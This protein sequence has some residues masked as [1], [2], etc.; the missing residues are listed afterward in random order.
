MTVSDRAAAGAG[1]EKIFAFS[2]RAKFLVAIAVFFLLYCV[3]AFVWREGW[4]DADERRVFTSDKQTETVSARVW[5]EPQSLEKEGV[6]RIWLSLE[7]LTGEQASSLRFTAVQ[8]FHSEK[9][10][11]A[12]IT[13]RQ[14][15][16]QVDQALLKAF[17]QTNQAGRSGADASDRPF[18]GPRD[19]LTFWSTLQAPDFEGEYEVLMVYEWTQ[20]RQGTPPASRVVQNSVLV[21]PL[22]VP[23]FKE[24]FLRIGNS[25]YAIW[26]DLALPMA[27]V[28]LTFM[29]SQAGERFAARRRREEEKRDLDRKT[30]E[31][32][33]EGARKREELKREEA[34]KEAERERD[35]VRETLARMLIVSHRDAKRYYLPWLSAASY[36]VRAVE[37]RRDPEEAFY[38][39][40]LL[41]RIGEQLREENGGFYL[42]SRQGEDIVFFTWGILKA[43]IE[44]RWGLSDYTAAVESMSSRE[45]YWRFQE[46]LAQREAMR[47]CREDFQ[48]WLQEDV[49]FSAYM[50][51]LRIFYE[52]LGYEANRP[53]VYW[54]E[55]AQDPPRAVLEEAVAELSK[56]PLREK[57]EKTELFKILPHYLSEA[58]QERDRLNSRL[59]G[60]INQVGEPNGSGK[61]SDGKLL[62][63]RSPSSQNPS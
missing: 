10:E 16:K 20:Q 3:V 18:L 29:F 42:K 60:G 11:P 54:Y 27:L 9:N 47:R 39:L 62:G 17:R 63:H 13:Q 56:G 40:M 49:P 36:L 19:R 2:R 51:L 61:L 55:S 58:E 5:V 8:V 37:Q 43:A 46:N 45:K 31:E 4:K 12:E 21:G 41:L 33:R 25:L 26:K 30:E 14:F 1:D 7:N 28:A 48:K 24:Q 52:T 35:R 57:V 44:K 59:Q 32:K 22:E 6:F 15:E 38:Y 34:R 50:P 53:L 23:G